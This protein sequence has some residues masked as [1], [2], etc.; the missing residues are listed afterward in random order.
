MAARRKRMLIGVGAALALGLSSGASHAADE[1]FFDQMMDEMVEGDGAAKKPASTSTD[2]LIDDMVDEMM[3]PGEGEADAPKAVEDKEPENEFVA[4]IKDSTSF[5]WTVWGSY[6]PGTYHSRDLEDD[7]YHGWSRLLA[8]TRLKLGGGFS[9]K[10]DLRTIASTDFHEQQGTFKEPS[11]RSK[12][13]GW[14][15]FDRVS[16]TFEKDDF[17]VL[18]GKDDLSVGISTLYSPADRYNGAYGANPTVGDSIGVWQAR[19]DY[20]I[21]DETMDDTL[22]FAITPYD[23]RGSIPDRTSRWAGSSGNYLFNDV[24]TVPG[25]TDASLLQDQ[26]NDP[27]PD[28]WGYLLHYKGTRSGYDFFGAA[29]WGRSKYPIIR[30]K[31]T[32]GEFFIVYPRALTLS[33]GVS[34]TFGSFEVHGE[35]S[36]QKT[37]HDYDQDIMKYVVG[38]SY[39]ETDFANMIGLDEIKPIIEYAHEVRF[40]E[41]S[42]ANNLLEST[43]ARPYRESFLGRLDVI[44]NDTWRFNIGGAYNFID[45]DATLALHGEYKH[46]DNLKAFADFVHFDGETDT[47]FG[48]WRRNHYVRVGAEWDF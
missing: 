45:K 44:V 40:D 2:D 29:H 38:G 25:L 17:A 26:F 28:N 9:F 36:G 20:Y 21:Q 3:G 23:Q 16:L 43:N 1:E 4:R 15:D 6:L 10:S 13:A 19:V 12:R 48:R 7:K 34:A 5:K 39:R 8:K 14:V 37:H 46:S 31:P 41:Q 24:S 33:G 47:Q 22:S 27:T 32:T 18:V 35:A 11:S 30:Q 42:G